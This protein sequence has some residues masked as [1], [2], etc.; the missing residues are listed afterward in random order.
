MPTDHRYKQYKRVTLLLSPEALEVINANRSKL[1][2]KAGL[3]RFIE[4]AVLDHYD[5]TND[6]CS[7][8]YASNGPAR[9]QG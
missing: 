3:S 5:A 4:R 8:S 9:K 7:P 1:P 6:P 2:G